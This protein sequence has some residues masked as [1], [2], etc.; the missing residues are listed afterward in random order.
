VLPFLS[1]Y[2]IIGLILISTTFKQWNSLGA[3][4]WSSLPLQ[5]QAQDKSLPERWKA[6]G[7][8]SLLSYH[9]SGTPGN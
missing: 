5:A 2:N 1:L 4:Q 8:M 6:C 9:I 7:P 3:Q